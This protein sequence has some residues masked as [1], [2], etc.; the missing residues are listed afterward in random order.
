MPSWHCAKWILKQWARG[1]SGDWCWT[2]GEAGAVS[3]EIAS[4]LVLSPSSFQSPR[5][6]VHILSVE[7]YSPMN[8]SLSAESLLLSQ[9]ARLHSAHIGPVLMLC[10]CSSAVLSW[11][12]RRPRWHQGIFLRPGP[13][14]ATSQC[15]SLV[16][17][18]AWLSRHLESSTHVFGSS[19]AVSWLACSSTLWHCEWFRVF[20]P[21]HHHHHTPLHA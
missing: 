12:P 6:L 18:D 4:F 8:H 17:L 19:L 15:E 3:L 20:L 13:E 11:G 16:R 2:P 10:L 21:H 7:F 5:V 14:G 9:H 1:Q